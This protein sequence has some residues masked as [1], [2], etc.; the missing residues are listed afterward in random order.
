MS[1]KLPRAGCYRAMIRMA[2]RSNV[3]EGG[4]VMGG[5]FDFP[6]QFPLFIPPSTLITPEVIC[7][8]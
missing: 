3:A 1:P 8:E 2:V 5:R 7:F 6:A 4:G